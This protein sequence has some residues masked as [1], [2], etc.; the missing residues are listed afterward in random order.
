MGMYPEMFFI[1]ETLVRFSDRF[2]DRFLNESLDNSKNKFP[3]A[4][5][6]RRRMIEI[7]WTSNSKSELSNQLN[8]G[9]LNEILKV[10]INVRI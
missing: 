8:V 9:D 7:A 5:A 4:A 1:N 3:S 10:K 6:E 2:A